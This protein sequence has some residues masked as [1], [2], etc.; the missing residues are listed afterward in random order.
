MRHLKIM[1]RQM[2]TTEQVPNIKEWEE[3]LLKLALRIAR[4]L[5]FTSFPQRQ[6]QDMDIRR[7]V[8]I[9]KIPGGVPS[10]SEYVDGAV[11]T[12]NVAH[13]K[14][15]KNQ[16][17]PRIMLVTFPL[18]Y[19]RGK[20][21]YLHITQ[22][23]A[24]EREF[25]VNLASR[26]A[27]L[28]PHVVLVE[29]SVSRL[30]LDALVEQHTVVARTVKPSAIQFVA[31]MTQGDVLSSIDK[32]A[33]E[34]RLGHCARYRIQTFDHPLIPGQR[35]T[36]MR[37]E[38]CGR[39]MGCTIL[40]RGGD[41]NTLRHIKKV[42][43]FLTFLVRN[44]KLETHLWKDSVITLPSFNALATPVSDSL[45]TS[46]LPASS[47][48][49]YTLPALLSMSAS[50]SRVATPQG[51]SRSVSTNMVDDS[52]I[53]GN[54]SEEEALQLQLS[55]QIQ[56]S[57]EPYT[58]TF[59]SVSATLRFPP[60]QAIWRMGELD[61]ELAQARRALKD[62]AMQRE[63]KSA[64]HNQELTITAPVSNAH[65]HSSTPKGA[66]APVSDPQNQADINALI[67]ALPIANIPKTPTLQDGASSLPTNFNETSDYFGDASSASTS[68]SGSLL[69]SSPDP[70]LPVEDPTSIIK[71]I[72][73]IALESQLSLLKCQHEEYQRIWKWFL[74]KNKD[75]FVLEKYQCIYV[76]QYTLP[77]G[78]FG[79]HRACSVPQL[80]YITFY[81][82]NDCT[83]AQFIE[84]S[85]SETL[86]SLLD[87]KAICNGKGCIQPLARHC[88]VYVHNE[89]RLFVAVEQWDGQIIGPSIHFPLPDLITTWSACRKCGKRSPH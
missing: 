76:W 69:L 27:A 33:L 53:S 47:L 32:L 51:L 68:T 21:Q 40:L 5:T 13:K 52:D 49:L 71:T 1:L 56:S 65:V 66:L 73:S 8:K 19:G 81:G 45:L 20:G 77:T 75:D 85:V 30:A 50:T 67:E 79:L 43:R 37:F 7:Y 87:S 10:D 57:L 29:K 41:I 24:Q 61:D 31:R 82:E 26:I 25:L 9:K 35:K 46:F 38:G 58:K 42:T 70:G 15:L 63:N 4:E 80:H 12:K 72:G 84:K 54:L 83:L 39:D 89:T 55:K 36:Y 88:Q 60:P 62:E 74:R 59:V 6:G 22:L 64:T 17:N 3:T 86:M 14:M 16:R 44:L 48:A 2:L 18:E 28:R 34:P 11:I 23:V 78:D